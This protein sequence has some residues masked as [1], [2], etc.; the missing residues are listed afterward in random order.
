MPD[1]RHRTNLAGGHG[2]RCNGCREYGVGKGPYEDPARTV[3]AFNAR[4]DGDL[5]KHR[6]VCILIGRLSKKR[7]AGK[8]APSGAA[9]RVSRIGPYRCI[10]TC[11]M[12]SEFVTGNWIL[13][14]NIQKCLSSREQQGSST[15]R[16][17]HE[18]VGMYL[19]PAGRVLFRRRRSSQVWDHLPVCANRD[20]IAGFSRLNP[21][22]TTAAARLSRVRN[23][24]SAFPRVQASFGSL[25]QSD[26]GNRFDQPCR[27]GGTS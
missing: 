25:D 10:G 18:K 15:R 1:G 26:P 17:E 13:V 6:Q 3:P 11:A 5:P 16:P 21:R 24:L 7:T 2:R 22:P 8:G 4:S 23:G 14:Y 20:R 9:Y 12:T 27:A 19:W